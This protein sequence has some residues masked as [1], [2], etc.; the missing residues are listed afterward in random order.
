MASRGSAD[1]SALR[2]PSEKSAMLIS[3]FAQNRAH[4]ADHARDIAVAQVNQIAFE[5]RLHVDAIDVQQPR[6]SPVQN[7]AF[8]HVLFR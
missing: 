1:V 8:H 6:R 4:F 2:R 3:L 5:R 7:R